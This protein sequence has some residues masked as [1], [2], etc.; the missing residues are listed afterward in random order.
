MTQ[1][2][3]FCFDDGFR[4]SADT[5]QRLFSE[6]ALS[7]CF[8]V[9]AQPELAQ[10]PFIRAAPIADWE[11][12]RSAL[13]AGH[14]VAPH[15]YAHEH[16]GRLDFAAACDSVQRTLDTFQQQLPGFEPK[17]SFF[18][19]AYLCAPLPIVQWIGER[20]LGARMALGRDGRNDLAA[21]SPGRP[22]DCTTF[23]P[24]DADQAAHRRIQRFIADEN[25]WLV[26]VFHGLD[27]EGWGTISSDALAR[28]LDDIQDA[29][30]RVLPPNRMTPG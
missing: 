26:L 16:L 3:S 29:G 12:W 24:P 11:Y 2:I 13:A 15:G 14:E 7:A 22:I 9:L 4:A 6:R 5:I 19:L 27:G 1:A 18:H 17:R 30:I 28:M 25:G 21:W 20:T 10:D 23:A 8:C